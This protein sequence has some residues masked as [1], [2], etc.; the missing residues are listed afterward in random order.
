[1]VKKE[2]VM[3]AFSSPRPTPRFFQDVQTFSTKKAKGTPRDSLPPRPPV[4]S[5]PPVSR[6]F[7][8]RPV[9][10]AQ[11]VSFRSQHSNGSF[12]GNSSNNDRNLYFEQE[13]EII[14]KIGMGSFGEVYKVKS[15]EDGKLYA[16]KRS[17]ER[18]RGDADRRRKLEE[19]A[20]H[21]TLPPHPNCVT[22]YRAWE[23]RQRLYIQAELCKISFSEYTDQHHEMLEEG[24]WNFLVDLLMAVKHLHDHNLVHMDIKPE[25]IFIS[26]DNICKLGDFGLVLDVS[27]G[28]DLSEAQEGDPKYIAPELMDGKFG[29]PADVFSLGMATLELAGDLDLPRGEEGWHLLRSGTIPEEFLRDKSFDLKYVIRQ[30]L[31]PDPRSRPT[32]DQV[33]AFPYV[34][35]MWKRRRREYV[36]KSVINSIKAM[37]FRLLQFVFMIT[38]VFSFP[39]KKIRE[40]Q[41]PSSSSHNTSYSSGYPLDHSISDDDCFE[42]DISIHNN[43]I[44]AP[45]DSSSSSDGFSSEFI[46]PSRPMPRHAFTT[47]AIRHRSIGF[48]SAPMSS[49]PVLP[50]RIR[51]L[52]SPNTSFESSFDEERCTTPTL[53][54]SK[55]GLLD[56]EELAKPC[57][58]P[59]NLMNMFEAASDED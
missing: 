17:H 7:P 27:K 14:C 43:S 29:K 49:S 44:G 2:G 19:V 11:I 58:G 15:K 24:I 38:S 57:I 31:D 32:V 56:T 18:F 26:Y 48:M 12:L 42:D 39:V 22:F 55:D 28:S 40:R 53:N 51:K 6:I 35:R 54:S 50:G 10:R 13:F 37:F 59:R 41:V 3:D 34:R 9:E 52:S 21:E 20:K 25:N 8:H 36:M 45:L 30:M 1:M 4:K 23:E 46:V 16:V 5:A 47:P 33:L